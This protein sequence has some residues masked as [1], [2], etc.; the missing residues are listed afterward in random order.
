MDVYEHCPQ[1]SSERFLL[2]QTRMEDRDD[3]L[4]VYSDVAAVPI[5]NSDNCTGDFY[6]TTPEDMENCIRF[7]LGEYGQRYYVRWSIVDLSL[8]EAVGT[9][10][11][12]NRTAGDFY[13]DMGLL[14][15][16]LR[17]DYEKGES[18]SAILGLLLPEAYEL[19]S[20]DAIATKIPPCAQAR[21]AALCAMGFRYCPE[22]LLGHDGTAYGD[23]YIIHKDL[24]SE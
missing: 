17:S 9:I 21:K 16:D 1:L 2:R 24:Q 5:F 22:P 13:N 6:I 8:G 15:L 11:L 3:L 12:F 4:K 23:Y 14:R 7:W 10:E 18:I 19:F 20:C